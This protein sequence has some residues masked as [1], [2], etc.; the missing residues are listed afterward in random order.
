MQQQNIK[1]AKI[2]KI[3]TAIT[4]I[5]LLTNCTTTRH[6]DHHLIDTL[7]LQNETITTLIK[8]RKHLEK[9]AESMEKAELLKNDGA[10]LKVLNALEKSN[11]AVIEKLKPKQKKECHCG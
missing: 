5:A 11:K 2:K 8:S 3:I 10:L 4:L 6:R 1:Q 7:K 9:S